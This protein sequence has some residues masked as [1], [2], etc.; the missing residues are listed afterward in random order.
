M[1]EKNTE[2]YITDYLNDELSPAEKIYVEDLMRKDENFR[3]EF[4]EQ[5][6]LLDLYDELTLVEPSKLNELDLA[7]NLEEKKTFRLYATIK[8][9]AAVALILFACV[10]AFMNRNGFNQTENSISISNMEKLL[11]EESVGNRIKAVNMDFA[12]ENSLDKVRNVLLSTLEK[13][14]SP[15]VRLAC[16]NAL[17]KFVDHESV[18]LGLIESLELETDPAIQIAIINLLANQKDNRAIAPMDNIIQNKDAFNFVKDEAQYGK[19]KLINL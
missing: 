15:H 9:Y 11:N 16:V 19:L 2:K 13:D 12:E 14:K 5:K 10:F 17:E 4:L 1:I 7:L 6:E 18:I 3:N 8:R